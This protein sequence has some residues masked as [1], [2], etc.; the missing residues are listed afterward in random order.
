MVETRSLL[1]FGV[2]LVLLGCATATISAT[3]SQQSTVSRTN[4]YSATDVVQVTCPATNLFLEASAGGLFLVQ[5]SGSTLAILQSLTGANVNNVNGGAMDST[6][7]NAAIIYKNSALLRVYK[8]IQ[9]GF[10]TYDDVTIA[11]GTI[12]TVQW[13]SNY[14]LIGVSDGSIG[15]ISKDAAGAYLLANYKSAVLHTASVKSIA[16]NSTHFASASANEV[17][18]GNVNPTTGTPVNLLNYTVAGITGAALTPTL[19]RTYVGLTGGN[20]QSIGDFNYTTTGLT[21]FDNQAVSS[22]PNGALF[23]ALSDKRIFRLWGRNDLILDQ[24]SSGLTDIAGFCW[25]PSGSLYVAQFTPISTLYSVMLDCNTIANANSSAVLSATACTCNTGYTWKDNICYKNCPSG[26][27]DT[28]TNVNAASCN[29]LG[30]A[31]LVGSVCTLDCNSD[32]FSQGGTSTT[33]CT[34]VAEA[35]WN[36]TLLKCQRN[37]SSAAITYTQ[38]ITVNNSVDT[39]VCITG[40]QWVSPYCVRDCSLISHSVG[41]DGVEN[42]SCDVNYKWNGTACVKDCALDILSNG[43]ATSSGEQCFCKTGYYW[44]TTLDGCTL[45]CSTVSYALNDNPSTT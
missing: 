12:T 3:Y 11:S 18:W 28:S 24:S 32:S 21:A 13:F 4:T 7:N 14:I 36:S 31:T 5:E 23:G 9:S 1:K 8:Q 44:N 6:G 33:A 16:V 39:C 26:V 25:T 41:L 40:F 42:C 30:S 20:V 29:C 19:G 15:A 37:C 27:L 2:L 34:C 22:A 38:N 35:Y 17:V 43:T 10:T 45:N